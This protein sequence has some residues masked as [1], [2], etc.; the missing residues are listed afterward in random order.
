ME[1]LPTTTIG[2]IAFIVVAFGVMLRQIVLTFM[3]YIKTKNDNLE[4]T[5]KNF[6]DAV[7][8]MHEDHQEAIASIVLEHRTDMKELISKRK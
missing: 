1:N 7:K 3:S 4:R 5:S 2:L 6:A 8:T